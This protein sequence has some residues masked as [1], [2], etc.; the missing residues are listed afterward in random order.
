MNAAMLAGRFFCLKRALD[1]P[2][3]GVLH[4]YGAFGAKMAI[5]KVG[6]KL[7]RRLLGS[8]MFAVA[9]HFNELADQLDIFFLQFRYRFHGSHHASRTMNHT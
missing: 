5:P 2:G 7:K 6:W 4:E 3:D 9:I 8:S 1:P